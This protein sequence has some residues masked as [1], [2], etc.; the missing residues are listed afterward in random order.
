MQLS[1]HLCWEKSVHS[2]VLTHIH[3][4]YFVNTQKFIWFDT[5]YYSNF[6]ARGF[7]ASKVIQ[8]HYDTSYYSNF[9]ARRFIASKVIQ[10]NYEMFLP[11]I[12]NSFLFS[13]MIFGPLLLM[14]PETPQQT[15]VSTYH[16]KPQNISFKILQNLLKFNS[17]TKQSLKKSHEKLV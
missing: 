13:K 12:M 14:C 5:S 1:R 4:N 9:L 6:L 2:Q 15:L 11:W 17:Q 8:M 7:I 16:Q 10:M 3:R